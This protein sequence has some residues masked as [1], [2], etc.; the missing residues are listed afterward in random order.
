[1]SD[2]EKNP[3]Q[4]AVPVVEGADVL[5]CP[6]CGRDASPGMVVNAEPEPGKCGCGRDL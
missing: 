6:S 5:K 3:E 1:M 4:E 2:D